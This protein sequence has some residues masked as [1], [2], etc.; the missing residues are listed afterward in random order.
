MSEKIKYRFSFI[1][2]TDTKP[3]YIFRKVWDVLKEFD[4][5]TFGYFQYIHSS[6]Q[7]R[8]I[9]EGVKALGNWDNVI[10]EVINKKLEELSEK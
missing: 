2:E 5:D 3:K 10:I 4:S 7:K 6:E 8:R 1:V 9:L